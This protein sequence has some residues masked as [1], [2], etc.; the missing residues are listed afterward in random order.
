MKSVKSFEWYLS[1]RVVKKQHP[2]NSRA[3]F[4]ID[5]A[6]LM[7][8]GLQK[9]M[10]KMGIDEYNPNSIVKECYDII[11]ALVRAKMLVKGLNASGLGAH[12]AE[13]SYMSVMGFNEYDVR[14]ADQIR[15]FR[16]GMLYYGTIVEKKYAEKVVEF[17]ERV[18]RKLQ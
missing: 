14:F 11:M 3:K 17:L 6:E 2:D 7:M 5:E 8:K 4:L 16:N 1:Q 10:K 13:I 9:R 15:Y 18:Y 12:E